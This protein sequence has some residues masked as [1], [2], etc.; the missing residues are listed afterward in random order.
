[1]RKVLKCGFSLFEAVFVIGFIAALFALLYQALTVSMR[2][3]SAIFNNDVATKKNA[4][5]FAEIVARN[6]RQ[7]MPALVMVYP[8]TSSSSAVGEIDFAST[9]AVTF[10]CPATSNRLPKFKLPDD[11]PLSMEPVVQDDTVFKDIEPIDLFIVYYYDKEGEVF[12]EKNAFYEILASLETKNYFFKKKTVNSPNW[13]Y[14]HAREGELKTFALLAKD[15][16]SYR[17]IA[18]N[19]V[20][21]NVSLS[22]YPI[23]SVGSSF[24]YGKGGTSGRAAAQSAESDKTKIFDLDFQVLPG[25]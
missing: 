25:T 15:A 19:M 4:Y 3:N 10:A 18:G 8:D 11:S 5:A 17:K 7:T 12:G 6:L 24:Y 20:Y 23:I 22:S 14:W 1:M 16:R 2:T 13:N 9:R 21:F